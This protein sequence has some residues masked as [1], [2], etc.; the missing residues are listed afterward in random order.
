MFGGRA[1][2]MN[3]VVTVYAGPLHRRRSKLKQNRRPYR[4]QVESNLVSGEMRQ[5]ASSASGL[6]R[7]TRYGFIPSP[8]NG[9]CNIGFGILL[10]PEQVGRFSNPW[11]IVQAHMATT[12]GGFLGRG[13]KVRGGKFEILAAGNGRRKLQQRGGNLRKMWSRCR[14][15]GHLRV[16][17]SLLSPVG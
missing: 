6:N 13:V 15:V 1:C 17:L 4:R 7:A 11:L 14:C 12:A 2:L 8:S 16:L 9:I 10:G 3:L 5:I